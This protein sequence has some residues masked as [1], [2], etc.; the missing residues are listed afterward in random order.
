M[1]VLFSKQVL[2]PFLSQNT[3]LL[4]LQYPQKGHQCLTQHGDSSSSMILKHNLTNPTVIT[5]NDS[6]CYYNKLTDN[7]MKTIKCASPQLE[8]CIIVLRN[9][10]GE[11]NRFELL[12]ERRVFK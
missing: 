10:A 5:T 11:T 8:A 1:I 7:F 3:K 2:Y 9:K 12:S 4:G 6:P